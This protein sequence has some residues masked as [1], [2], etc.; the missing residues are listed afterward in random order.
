M[1]TRERASPGGRLGEKRQNYIDG[2]VDHGCSTAR[3][4]HRRI[5]KHQLQMPPSWNTD[6]K[7]VANGLQRQDGDTH[8]ALK[9]FCNQLEI[10]K[11]GLPFDAG[12]F[13]WPF[14]AMADVVVNQGFLGVFDGT[15]H[16]LEL[17]S[18]FRAGLILLNH[19]DDR[20][21]VAIGPF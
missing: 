17:L 13:Q 1:P 14:E 21:E 20:F 19:F 16:R 7:V 11:R 8:R 5:L 4:E 3:V 18:D 6:R 10:P 2:R 9:I 15:L 12:R